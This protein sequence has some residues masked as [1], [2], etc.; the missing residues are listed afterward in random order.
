MNRIHKSLQWVNDWVARFYKNKLALH[1]S[2]AAIA[3]FILCG[4]V[5]E[6]TKGDGWMIIVLSLVPFSHT[7]AHV[8]FDQMDHSNVGLNVGIYSQAVI[9]LITAVILQA[10]LLT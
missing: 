4:T 10:I 5:I 1:I 2:Y 6:F 3:A 9:V 7:V 8:L